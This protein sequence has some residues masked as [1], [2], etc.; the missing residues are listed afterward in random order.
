MNN[1]TT[2]WHP[3]TSAPARPSRVLVT[4]G[5]GF[6]GSHLVNALVGQG[7]EVLVIDDLSTGLRENVNA[8]ARLIVGSITDA[9]LVREAIAA[10]DACIHLAAIAS[11]ERCNQAWAISHGVNQ[12]AFVA[13]LEFVARRPGGPFPVVYASSAAVYGDSCDLPIREV[14]PTRPLSAYGADK[15]GCELHARAAGTTAGL[16]TFGLRF[17]NV[18][19]AGQPPGSPYAGVISLFTE[20]VS[21]GEPV[22]IYGDGSH[23]RDFVHV[24]D[25]VRSILA[26]LG[27]ASSEAP[28][29]NVGTGVETSIMNLAKTLCQFVVRPVDIVLLP[30][31]AGDIA[32]S[33][34]DVTRARQILGFEARVDLVAGL[35]TLISSP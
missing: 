34:A 8:R 32:R 31:R 18:Y 4:G 24:S 22:T 1:P 30:A 20:R 33:V 26:A 3:A 27:C 12:S 9:Q 6:I 29:C 7:H 17:F 23:S 16:A 14:S 10:V 13:L 19:G 25:A 11:V 28:V 21:R 5:A 2:R 15:L 35:K